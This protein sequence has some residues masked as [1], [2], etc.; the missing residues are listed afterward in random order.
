[1]N[2]FVFAKGRRLKREKCEETGADRGECRNA[3]VFWEGTQRILLEVV[4]LW[5]LL[6][7]DDQEKNELVQL[8]SSNAEGSSLHLLPE[9]DKVSV[10]LHEEELFIAPSLGSAQKF[11]DPIKFVYYEDFVEFEDEF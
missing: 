4:T 8:V 6:E 5:D 9:S 2:V 3:P 7:R 10:L 11:G 1:M